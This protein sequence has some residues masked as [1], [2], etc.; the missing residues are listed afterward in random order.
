MKSSLDGLVHISHWG[1]LFISGWGPHEYE[2]FEDNNGR[3]S[4]IE[5]VGYV[6]NTVGV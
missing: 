4:I 6:R 1:H 3:T 5:Q 2:R